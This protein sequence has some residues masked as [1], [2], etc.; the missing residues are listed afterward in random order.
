MQA[1]EYPKITLPNGVTYSL[2]LTL[3]ATRR[4]RESLPEAKA[5]ETTEE[6]WYRLM[7]EIAAMTFTE[8]PGA[9][10]QPRS[11][12]S[13]LKPDDVQAMFTDDPAEG[14]DWFVYKK[15]RP[16][17]DAGITFHPPDGENSQS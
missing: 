17:V 14:P 11:L 1:I 12:H 10:G 6:A 8:E 4:V 2:R 7:V 13:G 5:T 9:N 3:G 16:L 15:I